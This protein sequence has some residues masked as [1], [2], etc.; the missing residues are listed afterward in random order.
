M[1]MPSVA[2]IGPGKI[3][4]DLIIKLSRSGNLSIGALIGRNY[5]TSSEKFAQSLE[6]PFYGSGLQGCL[7]KLDDISIFIDATT[8]DCHHK[9]L[10]MLGNFNSFII[11][12]TPSGVGS[13]YSPLACPNLPQR[14]KSTTLVSCGGQAALPI[15]SQLKSCFKDIEYIEVVSS[16][17]SLAEA[18]TRQNIDEYISTTCLD[19]KAN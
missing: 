18:R 13:I 4:R 9:H 2:V 6:V 1:F 16:M 5:G 12:L 3:G 7:K 19:K 10:K 15:L 11:D 8:A 14:R 17:S